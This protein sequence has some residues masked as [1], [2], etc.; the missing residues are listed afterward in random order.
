MHRCSNLH[1]IM[2]FQYCLSCSMLSVPSA[3]AAVYGTGTLQARLCRDI[4][5]M[6]QFWAV[7][8]KASF[9]ISSF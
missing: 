4:A 1:S 6:L 7:Q 5:I 9:C 3:A 8:D 2:M